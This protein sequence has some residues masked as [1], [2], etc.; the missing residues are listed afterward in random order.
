MRLIDELGYRLLRN[1]SPGEP[2][3]ATG[4]AYIG[5]SKLRVLLGDE[6][7]SALLRASAVIDFGCGRGSD[8][9]ELARARRSRVIGLDIQ[10]DLL[11]H[12]RAAAAAAGVADVCEFRESTTEKVDAILTMDAF[13][14]FADPPGI[15][16]IMHDLLKPGGRVYGA[17]GTTWYH[18]HGGHLFSVFPWAHLLF[19]EAALCQ[20]RSHI[21]SDGAKKFSEVAGGLNQMTI[22]QF[23]QIV[24]NSPFTL[25]QLELVPIRKLRRVHN[26]FTRE[27]TTSVVRVTLRR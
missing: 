16:R 22:G 18:P 5:K 14:H 12:A 6:I 2:N 13:E 26:K 1:I 24:A 17:F 10:R 19:S 23:E 8:T 4:A 25:E 9:I 27:F 15:L 7:I 21:R 20:W 11:E 3:V